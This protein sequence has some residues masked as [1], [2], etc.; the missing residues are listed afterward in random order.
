VS[1]TNH[2]GQFADFLVQCDRK[3]A[4]E[5]YL[6]RLD[7]II[8]MM[9]IKPNRSRPQNLPVNIT[10][11]TSTYEWTMRQVNSNVSDCPVLSREFLLAVVE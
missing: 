8:R 1:I 10:T 11:L 2:L 7:L 5:A 6:S 9:M 3:F 4:L